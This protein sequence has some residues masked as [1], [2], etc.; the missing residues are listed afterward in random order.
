MVLAVR[1]MAECQVLRDQ[2]TL[3]C[4]DLHVN[5]EVNRDNDHIGQD[6][7]PANQ[8]EGEGIVKGNLLRNLHHSKDDDQVGTMI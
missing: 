4:V 7:P 1:K 2:H 6:I 8:V 5:V 3:L